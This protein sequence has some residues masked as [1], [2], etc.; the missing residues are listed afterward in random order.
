M[1]LAIKFSI[2]NITIYIENILNMDVNG[3]EVTIEQSCSCLK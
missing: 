3:V 2:N 1:T